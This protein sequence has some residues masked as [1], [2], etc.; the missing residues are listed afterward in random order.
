MLLIYNTA[1]RIREQNKVSIKQCNING[2][3]NQKILHKHINSTVGGITSEHVSST[4]IGIIFSMYDSTITV[5][6]TDTSIT[7]TVSQQGPLIYF[8]CSSSRKCYFRINNSR[9]RNNVNLNNST[10]L[11]ISFICTKILKLILISS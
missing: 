1:N 2:I 6:I 11:F 10:I 5:N 3:N 9:I 4:A 8:L 7:N